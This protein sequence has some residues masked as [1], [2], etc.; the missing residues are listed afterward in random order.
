[1]LILSKTGL[2]IIH[3]EPMT[4]ADKA[5]HFD[6]LTRQRQHPLRLQQRVRHERGGQSVH[7]RR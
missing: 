7:G 1:V 5:E 2:S 6:K 3:F 4:L